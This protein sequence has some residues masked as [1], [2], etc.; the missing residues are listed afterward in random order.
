MAP[1]RFGRAGAAVPVMVVLSALLGCSATPAATVVPPLNC[2]KGD[3]TTLYKGILTFGTDQPAYPP[4]YIGDNP[5]NG[6]GFE[7]AVAYAVA[8]KL[9]YATDEVR[10]VRVPFNTAMAA[11]PKP[12]DAN[13]S[14]FSITEQRSELVDFSTPYYDVS[15]A[16]VTTLSSRAAKAT[17]LADL[18]SVTLGAQVGTTS[19]TAAREIGGHTPIEL[20]NTNIDAKMALSSGQIDALV[21]DLPTAVSVQGELDSAVIVGRIPPG[22]V[23]QFGIM[24][25]KDSQLTPCLSQAVD[26]L[27]AEGMLDALEARWLADGT[28]PPMLD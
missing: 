23:E 4:W 28:V 6:E 10:W 15:Q 19:S 3:L 9:G 21:L 1:M 22:A 12:F 25:D 20:Y 26:E 5:A 17:S 27:R 18:R 13:L 8:D 11:G 16:V 24:A 7:S 2:A 14:E